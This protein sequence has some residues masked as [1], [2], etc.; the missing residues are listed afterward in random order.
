MI[1]GR[2]GVP[3]SSSTSMYQKLI[4]TTLMGNAFLHNLARRIVDPLT[5]P[6]V[7]KSL[8]LTFHPVLARIP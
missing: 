4:L 2:G 7:R 8:P 5:D 1:L 6:P 3:H